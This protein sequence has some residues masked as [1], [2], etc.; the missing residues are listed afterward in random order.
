MPQTDLVHNAWPG[1]NFWQ[2]CNTAQQIQELWKNTRSYN[3]TLNNIMPDHIAERLQRN[4]GMFIAD[5]HDDVGVIFAHIVNFEQYYSEDFMAGKQCIRVLHELVSDI[6]ELVESPAYS[7]VEKIKTIGSTYMAASGLG[8]SMGHVAQL[9]DLALQ[10]SE[11]V[12]HFNESTL[13][14]NFQLRIGLHHGPVVAGVIGTDK[15]YYDIWGDTVN[16]ASRMETL[17]Q[18]LAIQVSEKTK[19]LLEHTHV[20]SAPRTVKVKGKG[21][22]TCY[23]LLGQKQGALR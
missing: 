11:V 15:M 5:N 19:R 14:Y 20:F 1:T 7:C 12:Q 4:P 21:E 13:G 6:D 16:V 2:E 22:M 18:A 10:L 23:Y 17:S 8:K 3:V 9:A